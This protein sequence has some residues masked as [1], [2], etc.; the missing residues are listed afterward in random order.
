MQCVRGSLHVRL[1]ERGDSSP[2]CE[3]HEGRVPQCV[4]WYAPCIEAC[5]QA[6]GCFSGN[7]PD[8]VL[9]LAV[10]HNRC[11]VK[12]GL[13]KGQ[14]EHGHGAKTSNWRTSG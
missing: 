12:Q 10:Q 9:M 7:S 5:C 8:L 4:K 13:K 11:G 14:L 3:L 1:S 6:R 2:D